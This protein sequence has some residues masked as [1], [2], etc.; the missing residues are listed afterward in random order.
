MTSENKEKPGALAGATGVNNA[1]QNTPLHNTTPEIIMQGR[2]VILE[3]KPD[4]WHIVLIEDDNFTLLRV[5]PYGGK[6]IAY[7]HAQAFASHYDA[8][9]VGWSQ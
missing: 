9:C 6:G 2:W 7:H 4:G 3:E 1:V 8:Q 5:L